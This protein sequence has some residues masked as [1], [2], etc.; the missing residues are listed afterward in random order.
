MIG[1]GLSGWSLTIW[2]VSLRKKIK[3]KEQAP[4]WPVDGC[5]HIHR[6]LGG[7]G[8]MDPWDSVQCPLVIDAQSFSEDAQS[9]HEA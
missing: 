1:G 2:E 3:E 8:E 4:C 6:K 7:R 5:N 9:V